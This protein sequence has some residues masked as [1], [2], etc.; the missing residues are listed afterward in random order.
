MSE[1]SRG[2]P[3]LRPPGAAA[4]TL[5][6][7]TGGPTAAR[8]GGPR[9]APAFVCTA[10]ARGA[11]PVPLYTA[12][13]WGSGRFRDGR[14][15]VVRGAPCGARLSALVNY[16]RFVARRWGPPWGSRYRVCLPASF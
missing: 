12:P 3:L 8:P 4:R 14:A 5:C 10:Q 7:V 11:L 2:T 9:V 1:F 13:D 6:G 15:T 16:H